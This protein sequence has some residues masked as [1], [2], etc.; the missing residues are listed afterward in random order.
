[1]TDLAG[2]AAGYGSIAVRIIADGR[3]WATE[4]LKF[5]VSGAVRVLV[6]IARLGVELRREE[7]KEN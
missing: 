6:R 7:R 2:L 5:A 1:L 4:Q 3:I